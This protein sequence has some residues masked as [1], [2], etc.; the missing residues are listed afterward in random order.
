MKPRLRAPILLLPLVL[1]ALVARGARA[2][3]V[4]L[5]DHARGGGGGAPAGPATAAPLAVDPRAP[6]WVAAVYGDGE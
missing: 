2:L 1:A 5:L 6:R 3:Q 4:V